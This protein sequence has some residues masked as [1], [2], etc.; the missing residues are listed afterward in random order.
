MDRFNFSQ[1]ESFFSKERLSTYQRI[2]RTTNTHL[3]LKHYIWNINLSKSLYISLQN[4]E[5][6]LRN[7][8]HYNLSKYYA[9]K[10]D[11][12]NALRKSIDH[13]FTLVKHDAWFDLPR[14]LE[15]REIYKI[16]QTTSNL[17]KHYKEI[18]TGKIVAELNFGFWSRLFASD[19]E[20]KIWHRCIKEIFPNMPRS[21]RTRKTLSKRMNKFRKLRNRIFHHEPIFHIE[22]LLEV[23]NEI[24]ETIGWINKDVQKFTLFFDDFKAIYSYGKDLIELRLMNRDFTYH[25]FIEIIIN[26]EQQNNINL[27][28]SNKEI[29]IT[30]KNT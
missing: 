19:Y 25:K 18:T 7:S 3:I 15:E 11:D 24:I 17:L 26:E 9:K 14:L 16:K 27:K 6:S 22:N 13:N 12:Y 21:I 30:V 20:I 5:V 29:N 28:V 4:L 2:L 8:I 10:I 1:I 23:H